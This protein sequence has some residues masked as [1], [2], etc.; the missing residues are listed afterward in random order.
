MALVPLCIIRVHSGVVPVS[1]AT[2]G[3]SG[4][5]VSPREPVGMANP[6]PA[7][8]VLS[9]SSTERVQS[10]VRWINSTFYLL[11]QVPIAQSK[12][13]QPCSGVKDW[14]VLWF[15]EVKIF[16]IHLS[17]DSL[18]SLCWVNLLTGTC[19]DEG[20]FGLK[21][22]WDGVVFLVRTFT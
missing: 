9:V 12:S 13:G 2:L 8:P 10:S 22:S 4:M 1:R 14:N 19:D 18:V 11:F 7:T 16:I 6:T 5:A 20:W 15:E 17:F 3:I 21:W